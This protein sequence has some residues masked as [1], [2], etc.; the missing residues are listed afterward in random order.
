MAAASLQRWAL[1]VSAYEY[2]IVYKEGKNNANADGLS[3]LPLYYKTKP[4]MPGEMI[5]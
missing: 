2:S 3:R 5:L 4:E 1:I